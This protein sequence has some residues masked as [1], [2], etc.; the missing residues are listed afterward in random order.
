MDSHK[1]TSMATKLNLNAKYSTDAKAFKTKLLDDNF[2]YGPV[3]EYV[4]S[5]SNIGNILDGTFGQD[6]TNEWKIHY[7]IGKLFHVQTLEPLKLENFE[8]VDVERRKPGDQYIKLSE[9]EMVKSMK[10]SH[11]SNIEARGVLY[12]PGV[13]Y[14]IPGYVVVEDVLFIGKADIMNPMI[15]YIGDLKSTRSIDS[16]EESI[17]KWYGPQL[18][19]YFK[20]FG[21]PTIYIATEKNTEPQTAVISPA[22][23]HYAMGKAQ[24]LEAIEIFKRDHPEMYKRN[25]QLKQSLGL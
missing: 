1:H 15:G 25:Q 2:Y 17:R 20:I 23:H 4:L 13:S 14:E 9:A 16:F 18:W 11:D 8:I 7:E 6:S 3:R 12:G 22:K 19:L 10:V 21:Y 24:V 5:A